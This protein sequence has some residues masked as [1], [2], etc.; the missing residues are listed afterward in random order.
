MLP[1]SHQL[2]I[3]IHRRVPDEEKG[4]PLIGRD[5]VGPDLKA[6]QRGRS[7]RGRNGYVGGVPASRN[8]DAANPRDQIARIECVRSDRPR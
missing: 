4:H 2:R 1:Q 5:F 3:A 7:E 6:H 8:Q